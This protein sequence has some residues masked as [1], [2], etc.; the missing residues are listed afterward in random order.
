MA[1]NQAK[2]PTQKPAMQSKKAQAEVLA[3]KKPEALTKNNQ[4][5]LQARMAE[6]KKYASDGSTVQNAIPYCCM[7]KDGICEVTDNFYSMTVQFFDTGYVLADFDE[8]NNIFGKYCNLLNSFDNSIQFQ[9]TFEN[10]NRST[11]ELI[12]AVQIP[13]QD[14]AFNHIRKEYSDMLTDKLLSGNAGQSTRKFLTF[15]V[16]A[17]SHKAAKVRLEGVKNDVIRFFKTFGVDAKMLGGKARLETLY[18]SLNPYRKEPF[19]FDWNAMLQAGIDTKDFIAPSSLSFTKQQFE[20][21]NAVGKI[22]NINILAGE[23]SDEILKD[24]IELPYLLGVNIHAR[25]VEQ[26]DALKFIRS[27]LTSVN[28]MKI[29]AQKKASQAGYDPNILPPSI[30]MYVDDITKMLEDLSSKDEKLFH[31]SISLRTYVKNK[32][33]LKLQEEALKRII[34]KNNCSMFVYDYRQEQTLMSTLPLCYNEI[35]VEREMLTSGIAIFVPFTTRELFTIG[36]A[37]YYGINPLSGNMIRANRSDLNNPNGLILG[38]PGSGK[39]FSVKREILDCFLTTTDDIIIYDPEGEYFPLVDAL[40]GQRIKISANSTNYLNPMDIPIQDEYEEDPIQ[41]KSTFILSLCEI[42]VGSG[43]NGISPVERSLIDSCVRSIYTKFLNHNPTL[44]NMPTLQDLHSALLQKGAPAERVANSLDMFVNGTQNLFN[45]RSNVDMNNRVVCFDIKDLGKQLKKL[46]ML[47]LQD[48]VWNRVPQNRGKK[49]T[50]YYIDE[51][52]LLLQDEQT[53]TY[54]AGI[55]KRFRKWGGVP[56]GITQN[57]KDLLSSEK[58]ENIFDNTDFVYMLNQASGDREILGEKLHIS[59]EQ[60]KYVE[61][62]GQGEGLIRFGKIILPFVDS[63]STD[64][65]M[66]RLMTTKPTEQILE[67]KHK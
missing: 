48:T 8:Q 63:F 21:G 52:H 47:I 25:P 65:E 56:T 39:S 23:L 62:S 2:K 19:V 42:I 30:Q 18:Y 40:H 17:S 9:L 15:G 34:S 6:I 46:G 33:S 11:E 1:K 45:H 51:F 3:K 49:K 43:Y 67:E 36:T 37:T 41:M 35:P 32:K 57:I 28:Q 59:E 53:A 5:V 31:I 44:E 12:A 50:R 58:I 38:T 16:T 10:Q 27:K 22:W 24:F 29:D 7:Y 14:D 13:E 54:S 66:Y 60:L 20:I 61:N 55:W 4:K 64:T 26:A